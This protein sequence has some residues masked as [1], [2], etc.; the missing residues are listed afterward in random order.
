[1]F[2]GKVEVRD[3]LKDTFKESWRGGE[4]KKKA[5]FSFTENYYLHNLFNN[6]TRHLNKPTK[7]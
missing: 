6:L 1:M 4:G 7:T 3:S 5:S 2:D